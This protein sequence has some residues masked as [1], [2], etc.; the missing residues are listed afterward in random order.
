[1]GG[2]PPDYLYGHLAQ[3]TV[4]STTAGSRPAVGDARWMRVSGRAPLRKWYQVL[5]AHRADCQHLL[6]RPAPTTP[7]RRR[8]PWTHPPPLQ[9]RR[10]SA[11]NRRARRK[12][13]LEPRPSATGAL[14]PPW[15]K[16]WRQNRYGEGGGM[17]GSAAMVARRRGERM[18]WQRWDQ[19]QTRSG[20]SFVRI[21]G[22]QKVA[23]EASNAQHSLLIA[24]LT[25]TSNAAHAVSTLT[26]LADQG[27]IAAS[28]CDMHPAGMPQK[29][30]SGPRLLRS[31][32]GP[33][34]ANGR[35]STMPPPVA[36]PGLGAFDATLVAQLFKR[37]RGNQ[38]HGTVTSLVHA[39]R[40]Y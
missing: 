36:R 31:C 1:M 34:P 10:G 33:T 32:P 9:P 6:R 24:T 37:T 8:C 7:A 15:Q 16:R 40:R 20:G 29:I 27:H 14:R 12:R 3:V 18:S 39:P 13:C 38:F 35:H 11:R 22:L 26:S 4:G 5:S 21:Q 23:V 19:R 2:K 28:G 30:N 17:G 25:H